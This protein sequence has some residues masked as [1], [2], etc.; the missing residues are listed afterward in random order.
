MNKQLYLFRE[1]SSNHDSE[2]K[3]FFNNR[4]ENCS[5]QQV[6]KVILTG[7]I[8]VTLIFVALN[9]AEW[10]ISGKAHFGLDFFKA[11][12][13]SVLFVCVAYFSCWRII[14]CGKNSNRK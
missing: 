13:V 7:L 1:E 3:E 8:F 10:I 6:R 4:I 11:Y 14:A 2:T 9:V 12:S 5:T